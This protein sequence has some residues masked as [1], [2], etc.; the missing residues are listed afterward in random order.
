MR[1]CKSWYAG[2]NLID[3]R[4]LSQKF[5]SRFGVSPK[6]EMSRTN[7]RAKHLRHRGLTI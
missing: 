1:S 7:P 3:I 2:G 5:G 4:E 6:T